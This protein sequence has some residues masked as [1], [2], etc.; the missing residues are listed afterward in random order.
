MTAMAIGEAHQAAGDLGRRRRP[1][2]TTVTVLLMASALNGCERQADPLAD[3][4]DAATLCA[5]ALSGGGR[6]AIEEAGWSPD[7]EGAAAGA[8][9]FSKGSLSLSLLDGGGGRCFVDGQVDTLGGLA[10]V[11]DALAVR[12][13][14][15]VQETRGTFRWTTKPDGFLVKLSQT[16]VQDREVLRLFVFRPSAALAPGSVA[17]TTP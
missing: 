12:L 7:D 14:A 8:V 17:G 11:S 2:R 13:G 4:V 6:A 3:V 15:P 9:R 16:Y 5:D 10:K 1:V